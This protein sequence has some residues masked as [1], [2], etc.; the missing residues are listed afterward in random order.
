MKPVRV[1]IDILHPAHVHFFRNPIRLLT[2][3]GHQVRVTSRD[4]DCT[5]ELLDRYGI[6]HE[7]I[8]KQS[9]G[10]PVAMAKELIT[11][12][13]AL[14]RLARKFK[15][16]VLTGIGGVCA[17]Q[18]GRLLRKPSVVFYDTEN[19]RL[20]NALTYPLATRIVVPK[21]YTGKVPEHKTV[22]YRGYHELSYLHPDYFTP[23]REIALANGLASTGDTFLIRLVSWKANHDVGLKGWSSELL[24]SVANF[25]SARGRVIISAEGELPKHLEPLRYAGDP[26]QIHHVMAFCRAYIGESA[27]MASE[28]TAMGVPAIYAAPSFRGYVSEQQDRYAMATYV[29]NPRSETMIPRTEDFLETA[30]GKFVSRHKRM[31]KD[32]TD[33]AKFVASTIVKPGS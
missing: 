12:D 6:E 8:S 2:D 28:A 7:C 13:W 5:L 33:V 15:P 4:K 22:R 29:E 17:A 11:R 18:V 9:S 21:C 10:G 23:N 1:L 26:V 32:C 3:A 14:L 19:A 16:D 31:L 24:E 30:S 25:L 27:T 20:Q